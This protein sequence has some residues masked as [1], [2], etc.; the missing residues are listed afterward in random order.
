MYKPQQPRI[1]NFKTINVNCSSLGS[2]C[3]AAWKRKSYPKALQRNKTVG[4]QHSADHFLLSDKD[5][6]WARIL[7]LDCW[8]IPQL[9]LHC[10]ILEVL[11]PQVETLL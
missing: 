2:S 7:M 3:T 1:Q 4:P 9:L 5:A 10:F 6:Q 11:F 8:P